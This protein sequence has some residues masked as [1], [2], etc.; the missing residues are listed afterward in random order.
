[1]ACR[2]FARGS[3]AHS[4]ML[5][6]D[7]DKL[8]RAPTPAPG[9]IRRTDLSTPIAKE[10]AAPIRGRRQTTP[11]NRIANRLVERKWASAQN[12]KP[13]D[14]P[15]VCAEVVIVEFAYPQLSAASPSP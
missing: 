7:R 2:A 15:F 14:R 10:M 1:M 8:R 4:R 6:C 9:G 11:A 3:T 12:R 13:A 5:L